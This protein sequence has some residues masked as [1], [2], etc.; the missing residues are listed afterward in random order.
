ME[1]AG[2]KDREKGSSKSTFE[3]A[4][5]KAIG[6]RGSVK[7]VK[8]TPFKLNEAFEVKESLAEPERLNIC[9]AIATRG[10]A[11]KQEQRWTDKSPIA[12]R[13]PESTSPPARCAP[14]ATGS[15]RSAAGCG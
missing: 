8:S 1:K 6:S 10:I 11:R 5:R 4:L 14:E 2:I 12:L 3:R 7:P 15:H 9:P 13:P